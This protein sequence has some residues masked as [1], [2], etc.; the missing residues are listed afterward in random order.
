[1]EEIGR[2]DKEV[3]GKGREQASLFVWQE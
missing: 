2:E 3:K 1:M